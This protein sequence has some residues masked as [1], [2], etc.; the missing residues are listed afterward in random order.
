[1][2]GHQLCTTAKAGHSPHQFPEATSGTNLSANGRDGG[3]RPTARRG[4]PAL[5]VAPPSG[6]FP[7]FPYFC[8]RRFQPAPTPNPA[9]VLPQR[10]SVAGSGIGLSSL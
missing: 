4:W 2:F 8:L 10:R 9:I 3:A 6:S 7:V 1:M 5:L